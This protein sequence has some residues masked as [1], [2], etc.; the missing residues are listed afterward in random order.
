M[1]KREAETS[2]TPLPEIEAPYSSIPETPPAEPAKEAPV[3]ETSHIEPIPP[4]I[5][6]TQSP[7]APIQEDKKEVQAE[8]EKQEIPELDASNPWAQS[9]KKIRGND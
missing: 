9:L 7:E 2:E 5:H 4:I 6:E 3:Q 8:P 1:E